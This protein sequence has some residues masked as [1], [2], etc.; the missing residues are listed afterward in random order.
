MARQPAL[1]SGIPLVPFQP[2]SEGKPAAPLFRAR[3]NTQPINQASLDVPH[4]PL[5]NLITTFVRAGAFQSAAEVDAARALWT[6]RAKVWARENNRSPEEFFT[7]LKSILDAEIP[8]GALPQEGASDGTMNDGNAPTSTRS[9]LASVDEIRGVVGSETTPIAFTIADQARVGKATLPS[10]ATFEMFGGP[11][12]H[13]EGFDPNAGSGNAWAVSRQSIANQHHARAAR[14]ARLQF[15]INN[16][17]GNVLASH[18]NLAIRA[19]VEHAL[20]TGSIDAETLY[21]HIVKTVKAHN[22]T[23]KAKKGEVQPV[24]FFDDIESFLDALNYLKTF[25]TRHDFARRFWTAGNQ[26]PQNPFGVDWRDV[27]RAM[28]EPATVGVKGPR[29]VMNALIVDPEAKAA[30]D[31]KHPIYAWSIKGKNI[32]LTVLHDLTKLAPADLVQAAKDSLIKEK[33]KKT[34][35][36]SGQAQEAQEEPSQEAIVNRVAGWLLTGD[37][38]RGIV[39]DGIIEVP[40]ADVLKFFRQEGVEGVK[41]WYEINSRT[42]GAMTGKSDVSSFFHETWHDWTQSLSEAHTAI[43]ERHFGK[44]DTRAFQEGGARAFERYLRDGNAPT[45]EVARIFKVIK[46]AML[47]VYSRLKGTP[48]E[49]HIHSDVRRVFDEVLGKEP[50]SLGPNK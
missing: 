32:G 39:K 26:R 18:G 5:D 15:T 12:Y 50:L 13:L 42:F 1:F 4:S 41:A 35:E 3:E 46:D 44:R 22:A 11:F 24:P 20:K 8:S 10:G 40:T 43:L 30:R 14:G 37:G 49:E 36:E 38:G 21:R 16:A 45:P 9:P 29:D 23:M 19:E 27:A 48:I 33:E 31:S 17:P 28:G 25:P 47:R 6:Q 34:P 7:G 2:A